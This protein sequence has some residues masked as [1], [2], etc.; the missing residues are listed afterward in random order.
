MEV[1][2]RKIPS[3]SPRRAAQ[4][5]RASQAKVLKLKLPSESPK[6]KVPKQH[7]KAKVSKLKF[8]S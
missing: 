1:P 5:G 6:A 4:A 3:Q 2:K 7:P 8:L